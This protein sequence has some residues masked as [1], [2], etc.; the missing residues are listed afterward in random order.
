[1]HTTWIHHLWW[2]CE[3]WLLDCRWMCWRAGSAPI[4]KSSVWN[5]VAPALPKSYTF[6]GDSGSESKENEWIHEL[7]VFLLRR[8]CYAKNWDE[9][10]IVNGLTA[11]LL[12]SNIPK[13][14]IANNQPLW[15]LSSRMFVIVSAHLQNVCCHWPHRTVTAYACRDASSNRAV[16]I[17]SRSRLK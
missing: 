15:R 5:A 4:L 9:G 2:V 16:L 17:E 7:L 11:A 8:V 10:R 12:Q 1:M 6:S 3:C 14:A 13:Y